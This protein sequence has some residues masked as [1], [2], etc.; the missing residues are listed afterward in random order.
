MHSLFSSKFDNF[1]SVLLIA[2]F[3]LKYNISDT[4]WMEWVLLSNTN[5]EVKIPGHIMEPF[6]ID[7]GPCSPFIFRSERGNSERN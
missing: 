6:K 5:L 2:L 7:S 4:A 1:Y 3:N